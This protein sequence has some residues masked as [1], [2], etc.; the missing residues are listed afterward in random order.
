MRYLAAAIVLFI[1]VSADLTVYSAASSASA[2]AP[3]VQTVALG[4]TAHKVHFH[5]QPH[6]NP[7]VWSH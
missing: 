6:A 5:P 7:F 1:G 3:A 4:A 2:A